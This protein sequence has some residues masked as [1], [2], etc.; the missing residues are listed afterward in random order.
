MVVGVVFCVV[1]GVVLGVVNCLGF[2]CILK[3]LKLKLFRESYTI[4]EVA[5][6]YF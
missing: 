3:A 5:F 1:L 4:H 2:R 6:R